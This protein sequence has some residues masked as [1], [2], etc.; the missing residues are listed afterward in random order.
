MGGHLMRYAFMNKRTFRELRNAR[1]IGVKKNIISTSLCFCLLLF[2]PDLLLLTDM[3]DGPGFALVAEANGQTGSAS[4]TGVNDTPSEADIADFAAEFD[5]DGDGEVDAPD[6]ADQEA[7]AADEADAAAE[8]DAAD[9]TDQ[10]DGADDEGSDD[11]DD[12][13]DEYLNDEDLLEEDTEGVAHTG[14]N[15]DDID[16]DAIPDY[17]LSGYERYVAEGRLRRLG[18]L[19]ELTPLIEREE[20]MILEQ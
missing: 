4:S 20:R 14:K 8:A 13:E 2:G 17:R 19:K 11:Q 9:D 15:R 10:G 5:K 3:V 6:E 12:R 1:S 16:G 18:G 7:D